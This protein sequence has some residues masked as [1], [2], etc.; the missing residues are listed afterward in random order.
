MGLEMARCRYEISSDSELAN[1]NSQTEYK[2]HVNLLTFSQMT[3]SL[4]VDRRAVI[5]DE[6]HQKLAEV[7]YNG[8]TNTIMGNPFNDGFSLNVA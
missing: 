5:I 3:N 1:E 6:G 2:S 4:T 8:P 7:P